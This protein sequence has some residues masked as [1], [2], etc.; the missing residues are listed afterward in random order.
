[1]GASGWV[2]PVTWVWI[3]NGVEDTEVSP[4]LNASRTP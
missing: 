4:A 2:G 1:M 3:L